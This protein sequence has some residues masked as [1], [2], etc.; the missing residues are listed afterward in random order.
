MAT[1]ASGDETTGT[2]EHP[3]GNIW[4]NTLLALVGLLV[5]LLVVF[6]CMT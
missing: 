5:V 2:A 6:F 3:A 1:G 4:M